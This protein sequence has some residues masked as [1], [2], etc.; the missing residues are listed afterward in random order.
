M[1]RAAFLAAALAAFV[2]SAALAE[3]VKH[4]VYII[5]DYENLRMQFS[6]K[7]LK[8]EPGDSVVWVNLANETH[9]VESYPGGYPKGAASFSSPWLEKAGQSYTTTFDEPGTYQ[10]HCIPH[11]L[12]GMTG[13]IVVGRRSTADEFHQPSR[14]EVIAYR[15]KLLEWFDPED[16]VMRVRIGER[17]AKSLGIQIGESGEED[18]EEPRIETGD[19]PSHKH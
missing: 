14:G 10:Y 9:N 3:P 2:H 5:S 18:A 12:M 4:T 1:K 6:P 16:D 11:L 19:T 17:P 13:E 7:T 8:I 15:D